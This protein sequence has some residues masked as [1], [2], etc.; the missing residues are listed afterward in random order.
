MVVPVLAVAAVAAAPPFHPF[1]V[2]VVP[3][4]MEVH[5]VAVRVHSVELLEMALV[6]MQHRCMQLL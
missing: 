4:K 6:L 1:V 2:L 3:Q 5:V